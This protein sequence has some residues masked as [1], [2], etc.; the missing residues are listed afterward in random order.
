MGLL[1]VKKRKDKCQV[2]T[3]E[4]LGD[5]G[6]RLEHT[7]RKSLKRIAQETGASVSS[8]RRAIQLLKLRLYKTTLIHAL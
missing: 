2:L 6:T 8:A 7:P 5:I 1:I 4:R 3:E